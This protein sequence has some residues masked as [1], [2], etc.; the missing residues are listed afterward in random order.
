[1]TA[2]RVVTDAGY[3][4]YAA[5][6]LVLFT[7]NADNFIRD[8]E[9]ITAEYLVPAT[10]T[11][12]TTDHGHFKV[13]DTIRAGVTSE[14]IQRTRIIAVTSSPNPDSVSGIAYIN[15]G[16]G[17][18]DAASTGDVWGIVQNSTPTVN[19]TSLTGVAKINDFETEFIFT[20][21]AD[22]FI[23]LEDLTGGILMGSF[24]A[25]NTRT[26]NIEEFPTN[27]GNAIASFSLDP[28]TGLLTGYS[29]FNLTGAQADVEGGIHIGKIA[30]D[31]KTAVG[32]LTSETM[33]GYYA[34]G[35]E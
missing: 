16:I 13:E 11:S 7:N 17:F 8:G 28:E 29:Q 31:G 12:N 15:S 30:S 6:P 35:V 3:E 1:M 19:N 23:D 33:D 10:T 18:G 5:D 26:Q 27:G 20:G 22:M 9:L 2:P 14:G 24:T 4:V 34:V 32:I 25:D 21:V